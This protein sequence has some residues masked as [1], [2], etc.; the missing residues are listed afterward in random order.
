MPSNAEIKRARKKELQQRRALGAE[1]LAFAMAIGLAM[2]PKSPGWVL[3]GLILMAGLL[4]F[5]FFQSAWLS[6]AK[7]LSAKITR[8][9]IATVACFVGIALYGMVVWPP[10]HR[11]ALSAEEKN[12]FKDAL[13]QIK[14][15]TV[16]VQLACAPNDEVDCEYASDL[17]PLFGEAH[18]DISLEIARITLTR[19]Q[20]GITIAKR[21][22]SQKI[23]EKWDEGSYVAMTPDIEPAYQAFANIGIE[24]DETTGLG[25]PENQMNIYVGHERENEAVPTQ[26]THYI[27]QIR[28]FRKNEKPQKRS[29]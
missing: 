3:A 24:P 29:Q 19:P 1:C 11:H 16:R 27:E 17:I 25:I 10:H 22:P 15:P 20:A 21:N 14:D 5:A 28:D 13:K 23:P 9:L 26:L 8:S 4:L 6:E 18:W 7:P 12:A 2:F